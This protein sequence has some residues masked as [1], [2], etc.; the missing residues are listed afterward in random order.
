MNQ[1]LNHLKLLSIFHYVLGGLGAFFSCFPFIYIGVGALFAFAPQTAG[2]GEPPPP[3]LGWIFIAL[4]SV[5]VLFLWTMAI[6]LILAGRFLS[7]RRHYIYC[8][9]IAAL[10]CL[11]VPFGTALGIFTIVV[12]IRP[13]VKERFERGEAVVR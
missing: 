7:A 5:G 3:A 6:C 9:V 1:D 4:G 12:L 10:S 8:L 11:W 13:T 2:Q